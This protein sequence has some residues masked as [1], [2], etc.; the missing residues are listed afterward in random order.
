[1]ST[2]EVKQPRVVV[3]STPTV[4]IA[5]LPSGTCERGDQFYRGRCVAG[6]TGGTGYGPRSGRQ[7]VPQIDIGGRFVV[8]FDRARIDQL[9]HLS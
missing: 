7:G 6:S 1:M 2:N 4:L 5:A 8:G 9:L 3:F